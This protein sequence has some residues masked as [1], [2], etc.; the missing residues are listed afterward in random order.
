MA[1]GWKKLKIGE[2]HGTA[3]Q[4]VS[5]L[6]DAQARGDY[7]TERGSFMRW[8]ATPRARTF[9]GL[10]D[11]VSRVTLA[12]L[13]SGKHPVDGKLIRRPGPDQ[14]MVGGIDLTVNPAPKSVS[15]LWPFSA[16]ASQPPRPRSLG[17]GIASASITCAVRTNS[18]SASRVH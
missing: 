1:L 13:L 17:P 10:G 18:C 6:A 2:Q 14:T 12:A 8:L 9:F 16:I 4:A 11:Q 7:Y 5:Y 3:E 15:I